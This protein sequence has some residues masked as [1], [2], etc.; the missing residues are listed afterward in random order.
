MSEIIQGLELLTTEAQPRLTRAK[1]ELGIEVEDDRVLQWIS[2]LRE[3]LQDFHYGWPLGKYVK[4]KIDEEFGFK[5][6]SALGL[7]PGVPVML[8]GSYLLETE[9]LRK[10]TVAI[11]KVISGW[12]LSCYNGAPEEISIDQRPLIAYG[13]IFSRLI[14]FLPP[15]NLSHNHSLFRSNTYASR[16]PWK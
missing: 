14:S 1:V 4:A 8:V 10:A 13:K 3:A 12:G 7:S 2:G 11:G 15:E 5:A 6:A 16:G 9:S